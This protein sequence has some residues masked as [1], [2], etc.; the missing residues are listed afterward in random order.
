M[1]AGRTAWALVDCADQVSLVAGPVPWVPS[2]V[3]ATQLVVMR[4]AG[5]DREGSAEVAVRELRAIA[6]VVPDW[7][8]TCGGCGGGQGGD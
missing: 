5:V 7:R 8:P 3:G 4:L 1:V 2:A 6:D